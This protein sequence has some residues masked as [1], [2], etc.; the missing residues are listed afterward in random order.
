MLRDLVR[1][2]MALPLALSDGLAVRRQV[3]DSAVL[4]R[5]TSANQGTCCSCSA[6]CGLVPRRL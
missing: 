6:R 5:R 4:L 3:A 2:R 1:A